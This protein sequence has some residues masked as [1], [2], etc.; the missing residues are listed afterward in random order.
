MI[1][2]DGGGSYG[3]D[4]ITEICFLTFESKSQPPT[5]DEDGNEVV[6]IL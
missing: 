2:E 4:E 6:D 3:L 5:I 1:D